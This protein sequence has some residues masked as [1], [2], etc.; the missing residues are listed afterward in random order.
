MRVELASEQLE[1]GLSLSASDV[2]K[3]AFAS[4][5]GYRREAAF[6]LALASPER[7]PPASVE[8]EIA[9]EGTGRIGSARNIGFCG[10]SPGLPS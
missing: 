6:W 10:T 8:L 2:L 5:A 1:R 4:L 9:V 7:Q 3:R